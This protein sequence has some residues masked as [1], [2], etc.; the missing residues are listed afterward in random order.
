M[1]ALSL[2]PGMKRQYNSGH[3]ATFAL[4]PQSSL[5]NLFKERELVI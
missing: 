2:R 5:P 4:H 1:I 3:K